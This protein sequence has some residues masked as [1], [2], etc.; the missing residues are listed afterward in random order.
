MNTREYISNVVNGLEKGYSSRLAAET[1]RKEMEL[2][3]KYLFTDD[4]MTEDE[5]KLIKEMLY[6]NSGLASFLLRTIGK[7]R[8]AN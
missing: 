4:T 3:T 1:N 6:R 8:G 5:T 7:R 2:I